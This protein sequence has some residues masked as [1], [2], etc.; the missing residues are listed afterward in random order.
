MIS[1]PSFLIQYVRIILLT[2]QAV[3]VAAD[4]KVGQ[5]VQTSS[6]PVKGHAA[7]DADQVSEY[8]GIPY[9]QP[10]TGDL[11]FQPTT[12]Y[13]G[14]EV[15]VASD[16][17][18]AC[19]QP[20][21]SLSGLGKR[22]FQG[23]GLTAAGLA[24]LMDYGGTIPSQD[25]DCLTLNIW[26]KPQTGEAKKAVLASGHFL[27]FPRTAPFLI[28]RRCGSMAVDGRQAHLALRGTTDNS[29]RTRKMWFL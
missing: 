21:L 29:L 5:T 2:S 6:G 4:W 9:A 26:T 27:D 23:L 10:P 14:T 18:H 3:A 11:R 1:F 8:L 7:N 19:M 20:S 16:F 15:I 17:G 28:I 25:E 12:R 13:N 22:Q 24:L